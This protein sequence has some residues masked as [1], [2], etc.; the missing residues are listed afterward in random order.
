MAVIMEVIEWV[1]LNSNDMIYRI[2]EEG[3]L[4]RYFWRASITGAAIEKAAVRLPV[5]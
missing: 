3:S 4:D 5:H 1:D 2:L